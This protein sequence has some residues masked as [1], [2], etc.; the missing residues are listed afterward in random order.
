MT[1]GARAPIPSQRTQTR[2]VVFRS[3]VLIRGLTSVNVA[4]PY[5][6]VAR[7][8]RFMIAILRLTALGESSSLLRTPARHDRQLG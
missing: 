2:L 1:D 3:D 8:C 7:Y 5:N 4:Q 6:L